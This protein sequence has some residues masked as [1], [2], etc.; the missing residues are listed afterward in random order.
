MVGDHENFTTVALSPRAAPATTSTGRQL[1][2]TNPRGNTATTTFSPATGI[3]PTSKVTAD[4]T[5][6]AKWKTTTTLDPARGVA[7]KTVDMNLNATTESYDALGRLTVRL[8]GNTGTNASK[9][10]VYTEGGQ[11]TRTWTETKTL[12]DDGTY[13]TEFQIFDGFM[14]LVQD[15]ALTP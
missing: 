14:Q 10:Y 12:R 6:G 8:P 15:Q 1:S 4:P 5:M 7:T 13:A 11:S 2:G 3:L 9:A